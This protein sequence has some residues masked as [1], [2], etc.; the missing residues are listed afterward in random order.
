[1]KHTF[2]LSDD[3]VVEQCVENPYWQ[4]FCGAEYFEHKSPL[5]PSSMTNWRKRIGEPGIETLLSETIRAGLETGALRRQS[6]AKVNV[7]TTVQEKAIS[8]PTGTSPWDG[9]ESVSPAAG[10]A[11]RSG[12]G[13]RDRVTSELPAQ[14]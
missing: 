12:S 14:E 9:C 2:N 13:V 1:M 5:D 4:Y 6:L 10:E 7:D 8:Y 3:L 11:G